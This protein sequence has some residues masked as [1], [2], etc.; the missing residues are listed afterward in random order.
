MYTSDTRSMP[1]FH[2]YLLLK[3]PRWSPPCQAASGEWGPLHVQ[4]ASGTA[5]GRSQE[6]PAS[7]LKALGNPGACSRP[8]SSL[9]TLGAASPG[10]RAGAA[11]GFLSL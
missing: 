1:A 7:P 5:S 10:I 3:E 11:L 8:P 9:W 4:T 6:K 2:Y